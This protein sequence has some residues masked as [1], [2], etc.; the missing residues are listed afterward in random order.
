MACRDLAILLKSCSAGLFAIVFAAAVHDLQ[1]PGV[2]N[3]FLIK[4]MHPLAVRHADQSVNEHHHLST[5]FDLLLQDE[6][7]F[8]HK[9]QAQ[10]TFRAMTSSAE[11]RSSKRMKPN[12]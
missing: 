9:G 7:N 11:A 4:T 8:L 2:N 3:D 12:L 5:A 10:A 1:H 6:F